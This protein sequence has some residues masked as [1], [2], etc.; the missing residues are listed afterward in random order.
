MFGLRLIIS[1][2]SFLLLHEL[3]SFL[4]G[5]IF[6]LFNLVFGL[7]KFL[8]DVFR[9]AQALLLIS[10]LLQHDVLLLF[11]ILEHSL[12]LDTEFVVVH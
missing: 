3:I 10:I 5:F 2:Y 7:F 12:G 6:N 11:L 8:V 9:H 4:L 1:N